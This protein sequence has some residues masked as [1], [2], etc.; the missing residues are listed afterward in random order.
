MPPALGLDPNYLSERSNPLERAAAGQFTCVDVDAPTPA[1]GA[2]RLGST[3]S[4]FC[5]GNVSKHWIWN[6]DQLE[7]VK[8]YSY[9][10]GYWVVCCVRSSIASQRKIRETR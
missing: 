7:R 4:R 10:G 5:A 3:I 1:E 9:T 2:A 8:E 6:T